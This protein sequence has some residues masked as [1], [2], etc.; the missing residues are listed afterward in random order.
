MSRKL[1]TIVSQQKSDFLSHRALLDEHTVERT[2][3]VSLE[4]QPRKLDSSI[5]VLPW[6]VLL[7]TLEV[8]G[9]E[10]VEYITIPTIKW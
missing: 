1:L 10:R 7:E 2:I 9:I 3:I 6:K 5:E 8:S 4:K